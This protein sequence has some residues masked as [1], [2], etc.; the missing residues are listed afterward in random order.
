MYSL[1]LPNEIDS[2]KSKIGLLINLFNILEGRVQF[3]LALSIAEAAF[4]T[5]YKNNKVHH[6]KQLLLPD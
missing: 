1:F 5:V 6:L 3:L 2:D 4:I